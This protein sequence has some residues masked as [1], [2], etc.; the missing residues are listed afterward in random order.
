MSDDAVDE[1]E[2]TLC[3]ALGCANCAVGPMCGCSGKLGF[4]CLNMEFCCKP[5]APCLPCCCIGP[6]CESDG[7]S[8][9][10][11]QYQCCCAV[12]SAAFP[13]NEEVPVALSLC[14]VTCFPTC[15]C[16]VKQAVSFFYW[17][18]LNI[19][20]PLFKVSKLTLS[21]FTSISVWLS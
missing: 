20:L 1:S 12:C 9:V 13:C 11:A 3:C 5:G 14:G 16:C 21:F 7:C 10:N 4:C 2:L 18:Y 19:C 6:K 8:L 17:I 15:G